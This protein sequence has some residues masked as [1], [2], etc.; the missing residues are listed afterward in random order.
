[1]KPLASSVLIQAPIWSIEIGGA[2]AVP[3]AKPWSFAID[4]A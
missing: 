3:T 2:D 1:M 4:F